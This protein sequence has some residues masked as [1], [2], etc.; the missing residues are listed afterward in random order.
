MLTRRIIPCLDVKHGRVV[1]GIQFEGLR[2]MGDPVELSQRYA[3]GGADELCLLDVSASVDGVP[4]LLDVVQRV[5]RETF[6][7]FTVGGGIRTAEDGRAALRAG[8]DK[9]ALNTAALKDPT[10]LT[11]FTG[12]PQCVVYCQ[13]GIS[14]QINKRVF[15]SETNYFHYFSPRIPN[16]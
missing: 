3:Q 10:L 16:L 2:D 11:L 4:L 13:V 1:K 12:S 9:V 7:P 14:L 6:V 15:I 5:A 8:A